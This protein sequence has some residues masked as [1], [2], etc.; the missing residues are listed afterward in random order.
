MAEIKTLSPDPEVR[1]MTGVAPDAKPVESRL[2]IPRR[3]L[4]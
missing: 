4:A 3:S 2:D 1:Q